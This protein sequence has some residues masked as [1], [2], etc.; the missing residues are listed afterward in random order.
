MGGDNEKG[1]REGESNQISLD[2]LEMETAVEKCP[3]V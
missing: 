1:V 2:D 3:P